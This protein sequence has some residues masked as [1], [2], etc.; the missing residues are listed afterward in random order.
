MICKAEKD[1]L[2]MLIDMNILMSAFLMAKNCSTEE[3]DILFT[4]SKERLIKQGFKDNDIDNMIKQ[5]KDGI[6]QLQKAFITT[7]QTTII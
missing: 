5:M 4:A 2:A 1:Q 6:K 7:I 3:I